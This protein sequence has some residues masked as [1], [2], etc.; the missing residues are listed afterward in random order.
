MET[1]PDR[2]D[3]HDELARKKRAH[4]FHAVQQAY[5]KLLHYVDAREK[6][7]RFHGV[8]HHVT[9]ASHT[10][11]RGPVS[12]GPSR[13]EKGAGV[14]SGF[15]GAPR[16]RQSAGTFYQNNG[17][18]KASCAQVLYQ[19]AIPDRPLLFGHYLYY[20]GQVSWQ[21]I[22]EALMWQRA[23]RPRLGE[24]AKERGW[25]NSEKVS[26]VL[27]GSLR[28]SLPFGQQAVQQGLLTRSQL[29]ALVFEQKRQHKKFGQFFVNQKILTPQQ[30]QVQL[31]RFQRHNARLSRTG[32][33]WTR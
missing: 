8:V 18:G 6:G 10:G 17:R 22:I 12:P 5:E 27:K 28:S 16:T 19:G 21:S 24:I 1:H 33:A 15:S 14:E 13:R 9:G 20:A 11:G 31:F 7:F 2:M 30:L 4:M 3:G 25:L 29:Q 23:Q 32:S 26:L